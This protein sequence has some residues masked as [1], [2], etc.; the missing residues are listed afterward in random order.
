MVAQIVDGRLYTFPRQLHNGK[1][2]D[3]FDE[4]S[5]QAT[6]QDVLDAPPHVIA[7]IVDGRLYIYPRPAAPHAEACSD[8]RNDSLLFT[9]AVADRVVGLFYSNQNFI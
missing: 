2:K 4:S 9:M 8:F 7:Q 5:R 1:D 3:S 6:Y